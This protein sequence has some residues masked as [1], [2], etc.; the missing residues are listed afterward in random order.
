MLFLLHLFVTVTRWLC[1]SVVS[2]YSI[3]STN[4]NH[5]MMTTK[6]LSK[7][8]IIC[9]PWMQPTNQPSNNF[10]K[11]TFISNL[12]TIKVQKIALSFLPLLYVLKKKESSK[13]FLLLFG[14]LSFCCMHKRDLY[15]PT[16]VTKNRLEFNHF[17]YDFNCIMPLT[18]NTA[19]LNRLYFNFF[20]AFASFWFG[21]LYVAHNMRQ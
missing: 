21:E 13:R 14:L 7:T 3:A 5:D 2:L 10:N 20:V 1:V 8:D 15:V 17:N 12:S 6:T 19:S 16:T 18:T 4:Y 11:N 9:K